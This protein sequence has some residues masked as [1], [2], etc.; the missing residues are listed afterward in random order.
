[1]YGILE[2]MHVVVQGLLTSYE[3]MGEGRQVVILHGWGDSATG[4]QQFARELAKKYEVIVPDLP[5]FGGTQTPGVV[6]GLDEYAA[7]VADFITKLK[8]RPYAIAGHSNGGAIAIRG[9]GKKILS[10]RKLILLASAGVRG[11]Q[12]ARNQ[13]LLVATKTGKVFVKPLPR[14]VKRTIQKKLYQAVGSDMLVAEHLKETF[15]RVVADDVRADAQT[16]SVPTLLLYGA[17]DPAAPVA[18]GQL[19]HECIA[20]STLKVLPH[21]EH[22]LHIDHPDKV[23]RLTEEFLK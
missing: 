1:M 4:W 11:Q 10:A 21:T 8:L 20:G 14:R 18:Y 15:K 5:G 17:D 7:F 16:I 19:F 2:V 23:L 13:A 9:M 22:F 6:W 3:R 12:K